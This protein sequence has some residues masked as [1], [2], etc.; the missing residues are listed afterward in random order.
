MALYCFFATI[1][2]QT[3]AVITCIGGRAMNAYMRGFVILFVLLVLLSYL[4]PGK[5][6]RKYIRFYAQLLMV[7]AA[8]RPLFVL[9]GGKDTFYEKWHMQCME[10]LSEFSR[11]TQKIAYLNRDRYRTEYENVIAEN[12]EEKVDDMLQEYGLGAESVTVELGEDH[13]MVEICI[14]SQ[15]RTR[16]RFQSEESVCQMRQSRGENQEVCGKVKEE[17]AAYYG[18][19]I[20]EYG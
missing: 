2:L 15:M 3:A 5:Q 18:W 12:I 14:T 1:A 19:R 20:P 11:D 8:L 10:K 7:L 4:P 17:L 13:T 6:Y 9:F 16:M